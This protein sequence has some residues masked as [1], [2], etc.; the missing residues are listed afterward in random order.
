MKQNEADRLAKNL[1]TKFG[2]PMRAVVEL[3]SAGQKIV[4]IPEGIHQN[5]GFQVVVTVGWRSLL[6]ELVPGKFAASLLDEMAL[7]S[8]EKKLVFSTIA[9]EIS[10]HKGVLTMHVNDVIV[11]PIKL[12]E[13]PI[14]W[15]SLKMSLKKTPLEIN[16]DDHDLSETLTGLWV[17]RFFGC[18]IALSPLEEI[19]ELEDLAA[20]PEGAV[21]KVLV[22]RY[23]R[24][25]FNRTMCINFHGVSCKV[26]GVSFQSL[27]GSLGEGFIHVHHTVPVST[28]GEGYVINPIKDLIPVCPNCHAMLHRRTPPLSIEELKKFLKN[29]ESE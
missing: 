28:L 19:E 2:L 3:N 22:N 9:Q 18:V 6:I 4:V 1:V 16:T 24:N 5:E 15:K 10:K 12:E 11:D 7:C 14:K 21:S 8:M 23:E 25:R 27:Y 26:C 29:N 20:Y 17:E 13:W